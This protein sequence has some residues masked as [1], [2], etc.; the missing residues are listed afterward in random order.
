MLP[1]NLV[2]MSLLMLV[3]IFGSVGTI[4][5]YLTKNSSSRVSHI[6]S[7]AL[8][9]LKGQTPGIVLSPLHGGR[10][11]LSA[12]QPL[13]DYVSTSY[14]SALTGKQEFLSDKINLDITGVDYNSKKVE[15]MRFYNTNDI[16]WAKQFLQ[17]NNISYVYETPIKKL[18]ISPSDLGLMPLFI[19]GEV[20]LYKVSR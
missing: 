4:R 11:V 15:V 13:Y 19:S 3:G 10:S 6:E 20:N 5:D 12:P 18:T 14:I 2:F 7:I 1:K 16:V 9:T 8:S 17:K